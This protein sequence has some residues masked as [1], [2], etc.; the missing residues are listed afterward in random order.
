[1]NRRVF[2]LLCAFIFLSAVMFADAVEYLVLCHRYDAPEADKLA[3]QEDLYHRLGDDTVPV[4][5]GENKIDWSRQP[6]WCKKLKPEEISSILA[7]PF[8]NIERM[9]IDM[10]DVSDSEFNTSK[11]NLVQP[12]YFE[13]HR[14][15]NIAEV[16]DK[17]G[18]EPVSKE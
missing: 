3:V 17:A 12:G 9:G 16:L 4:T 13:V 1:M 7:V 8:V 11:T 18:Y 15:T 10:A 2:Y 14:G 6:R 5:A